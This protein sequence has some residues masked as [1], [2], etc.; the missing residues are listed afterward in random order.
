MTIADTQGDVEFTG[1]E[2]GAFCDL[3][4]SLNK[5][6][7]FSIDRLRTASRITRHQS[8]SESEW[9][10]TMGDRARVVV[11]IAGLDAAP[12]PAGTWTQSGWTQPG[13]MQP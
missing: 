9:R 7:R 12:A 5:P 13:W 2:I 11:P 8:L 4:V 10:V 3:L 1:D 6:Q